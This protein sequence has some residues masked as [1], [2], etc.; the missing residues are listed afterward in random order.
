MSQDEDL[1][2]LTRTGSKGNEFEVYLQTGRKFV[3]APLFIFMRRNVP[4]NSLKR[5]K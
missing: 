4:I 5:A 1:G 3:D 2:L